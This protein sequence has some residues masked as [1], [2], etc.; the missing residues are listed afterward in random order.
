MTKDDLKNI[1]ADQLDL[2]LNTENAQLIPRSLVF[3]PIRGKANVITGIRRSGK[4][5]YLQELLRQTSKRPLIMT[6]FDERL[7][8]FNITHF[9][10]LLEVYAELNSGDLPDC[11]L[12]D[13]VQLVTGWE[14]FVSRLIQDRNILVFLTGSSAKLLSK[15]IATE[16]RGRALR[17]ELFPFSFSEYLFFYK[18]NTK[19]K[20]T[21]NKGLISKKFTQYMEWGGFPELQ[22][23]ETINKRKLLN[24]YL[25]VLL[26][27]DIIERNHF[28]NTTLARRLF[29][30]FFRQYGCLTSLNQM[31]N[32]L[33]SEGVKVD[34]ETISNF[35]KWMEDAYVIY[36]VRLYT[37]SE[38]KSRVNPVKIYTCDIGLIHAAEAYTSSTMG[39]RFENLVFIKLRSSD[40]YKN[41]FYYRT[42]NNYEVDF[43]FENM[44]HSLALYQ[45]CWELN[46]DSQPRELRALEL[47]MEEL[48]IKKSFLISREAAKPIRLSSGIVEIISITDFLLRKI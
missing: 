3:H 15:E 2:F 1:M 29:I 19:L 47:A 22:N 23:Q 14:M 41:I 48:G 21:K 12:L 38:H 10:W 37:D 28:T 17:Y 44:D 40:S 42:I 46:Q 43:V 9:D 34:K 6:F 30:Q 16:L 45:V 11:I 33:K 25:E 27:R 20:T 31:Y 4:S 7:N 13:E 26:F 36:S 39:R 24:E 35:L 8:E 5:I 18:V 32:K